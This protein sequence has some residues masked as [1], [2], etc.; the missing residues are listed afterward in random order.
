M[1]AMSRYDKENAIRQVLDYYTPPMRPTPGDEKVEACLQLAKEQCAAA[2]RRMADNVDALTVA[3][4]FPGRTKA[5]G[6]Q[7]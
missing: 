2:Y 1:S 3:D 6:V 4:V 5:T 7:S